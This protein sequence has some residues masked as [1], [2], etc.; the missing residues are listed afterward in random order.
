MFGRSSRTPGRSP[1]CRTRSSTST[2][3]HPRRTSNHLERSPVR[4]GE[5]PARGPQ[6][7][8]PSRENFRRAPPEAPARRFPDP[9]RSQTVGRT[10][11]RLCWSILRA[12]GVRYALARRCRPRLRCE[13]TDHRRC[14]IR[15]R[16]VVARCPPHAET[17]PAGGESVKGFGAAVS[18][19]SGPTNESVKQCHCGICDGVSP[20]QCRR[21]SGDRIPAA[22]TLK[23]IQLRTQ[24]IRPSSGW[25]KSM[26]VSSSRDRGRWTLVPSEPRLVPPRS[27][28]SALS[29]HLSIGHLAIGQLAI[30]QP[31]G[32]D[33][34]QGSIAKPPRGVA[35]E[36]SW[37]GTIYP[38]CLLRLSGT[39]LP[40]DTCGYVVLSGP[41]GRAVDGPYRMSET[42]GWPVPQSQC[43]LARPVVG[44]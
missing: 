14:R 34:Q 30:G 12:D 15:A 17:L 11:D 44:M 38:I 10:A 1:G 20:L 26:Y 16:C 7:V 28:R 8:L 4:V 35:F 6:P 36:P 5:N 33:S 40:A 32:A 25:A 37:R 31:F 9:R 43:I 3:R 2:C 21:T 22:A 41:R 42:G 23:Q 19:V 39:P 29:L 18:D 13:P 24:S 27:D